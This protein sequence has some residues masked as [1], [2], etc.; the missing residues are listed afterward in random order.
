MHR[1]RSSLLLGAA[2]VVT[3]G[4]PLQ[5]RTQVLHVFVNGHPA[6]LDNKHRTLYER[7]RAR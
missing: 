6:S 5:I 3:D 7:Y 4:S 1:F 2:L